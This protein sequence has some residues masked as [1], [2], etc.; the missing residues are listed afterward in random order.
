MKI[1]KKHLFLAVIAAGLLALAGG[2]Y[3][4]N[5]ARLSSPE[6]ALSQL[7]LSIQKKD[8]A[9]FQEYTN[10][11]LLAD[12]ILTQKLQVL[13]YKDENKQK[14][15]KDDTSIASVLTQ[16]KDT[17]FKKVMDFMKP[18]LAKNIR[19]QILVLV[20]TGDFG[21]QDGL[22]GLYQ[23]EPI[24][25]TIWQQFYGDGIAFKGFSEFKKEEGKASV[26]LNFHRTDIDHAGVLNLTF[27]EQDE[28]WQFTG[29]S[30]LKEVLKTLEKVRINHVIEQNSQVQSRM[31]Q[32]LKVVTL[33]KSDNV[34]E[35]GVGQG[36]HL[37]AAFENTSEQD[38]ASFRATII[39]K[40][41]AGTTLREVNLHDRDGVTVSST[42][43][44][45]WPMGINPLSSADKEIYTTKA[46]NLVLLAKI[47]SITFTDGEV[48][49]LLPM[50]FN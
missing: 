2:L 5:Q 36:I 39:F 17:G 24:L 4:K 14:E 34:S 45:S 38:V 26:S 50:D 21:E 6:F 18:E 11:D 22:I 43:E 28:K 12:N 42:T 1:A 44:K 19:E 47:N 48:L 3:L 29:F 35:W 8:T 32:T 30:N 16:I 13:G 27:K 33:E 25:Q 9:L 15:E 41:A 23:K 40:N 49:E 37:L 10:L 31:N 46:E 20:E 7:E